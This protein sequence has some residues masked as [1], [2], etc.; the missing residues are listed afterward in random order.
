MKPDSKFYLSVL[1]RYHG[2]N[3][4]IE[5]ES[6]SVWY[7]LQPMGK[8]KL[9]ELAKTMSEKANLSGRK[10]NHSARKT[11]VTSLLHSNV[12]ATTVMQLTGHKN[13]ES[14]NEY[15]SAS[16]DQQIRMSNILSDIGTGSK[17]NTCSK[18]CD[19]SVQQNVITETVVN[20]SEDS[21]VNTDFFTNDNA[22]DTL[23]AEIDFQIS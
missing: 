15:A 3:S 23:L 20:D 14:V 12:E 11:T 21:V 16:L 22:G 7:S 8:N 13:V 9:G 2:N 1:P 10:V 5:L 19:N 18:R 4:N 17:T 6:S